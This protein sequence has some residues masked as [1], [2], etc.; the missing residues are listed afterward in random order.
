MKTEEVVLATLKDVLATSGITSSEFRRDRPL[1]EL[2]LD[3]LDWGV[4]MI[5]LERR[6]GVDPFAEPGGYVV[7]T[8]V[9]EL[10]DF[11]ARRLPGAGNGR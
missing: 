6:L 1:R 8:T 11:Y 7:P 10:I 9:G 5:H 2:G 4:A 3:S